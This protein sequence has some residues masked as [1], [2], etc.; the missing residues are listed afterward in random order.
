ML[1]KLHVTQL[2]ILCTQLITSEETWGIKW[3]I[4]K[5]KTHPKAEWLL[6]CFSISVLSSQVD[7]SHLHVHIIS[8]ACI[9]ISVYNVCALAY[10]TEQWICISH[11]LHIWMRLKHN[12]HNV[13]SMWC[14]KVYESL[15][16]YNEEILPCESLI[17]KPVHTPCHILFSSPQR[18]G[19]CASG[20]LV[21]SWEFGKRAASS[22][23][24]FEFLS[25]G[26]KWQ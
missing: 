6:Q 7:H 9:K 10:K 21:I 25:W 8:R 2:N 18:W 1:W 13:F 4:K 26:I 12:I 16:V 19:V 24:F 3:T 23:R 5:Y 20:K 14:L 17:I 22:F 15:Y 11:G